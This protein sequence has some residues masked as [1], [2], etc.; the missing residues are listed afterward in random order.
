[1]ET[2]VVVIF[3]AI[4][5]KGHI[6]HVHQRGDFLGQ[7]F[8]ELVELHELVD[9]AADFRQGGAVIDPFAV[10]NFFQEALEPVTEGL[11]RKIMMMMDKSPG[12]NE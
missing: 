1:M 7:H 5:I 2:L 3:Q 10:E 11:E 8:T 9:M 4:V 12:K 6:P